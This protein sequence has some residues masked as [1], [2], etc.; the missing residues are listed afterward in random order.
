MIE[1]LENIIRYNN[2][3][4]SAVEI[5][6]K[7]PPE[8]MICYKKDNYLIETVNIIRNYDIPFLKEKIDM[9]K[10]M[11]QEQIKELYKT[12]ITNGKFSKKGGAGLGIIEMAKV[13]DYRIDGHF[14][15]LDEDFSYF[16]LQ[17]KIKEPV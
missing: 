10:K 14:S 1:S 9:L 6:K 2:S 11:D 4:P 16:T 7:Y 13:A 3:I 15:F 17:L 8:F 5:L 12:T